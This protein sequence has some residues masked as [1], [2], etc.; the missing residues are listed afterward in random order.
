MYS[1]EPTHTTGAHRH[2]RRLVLSHT[3]AAG[4][5]TIQLN[6]NGDRRGDLEYRIDGTGPFLFNNPVTTGGGNDNSTR[7][8]TVGPVGTGS[9]NQT[10]LIPSLAIGHGGAYTVGGA[11][12]SAVFLDGFTATTSGSVP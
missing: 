7:V 3:G 1:T 8:I 5:G 9:E 10:V 6:A 12:S 4:T 11:G 2:A